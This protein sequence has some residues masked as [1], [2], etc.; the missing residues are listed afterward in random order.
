MPADT[1]ERDDDTASSVHSC[2]SDSAAVKRPSIQVIN[3][4]CQ[5]EQRFNEYSLLRSLLKQ[6]L[7]FHNND[8]TQPEREQYILRLF[9]IT[10]TDD[11]H[12]RQNLF[13]LNDLCDV[14]FQHDRIEAE[15]EQDSNFVKSYEANLNELLSHM[16]HKLI[17]PSAPSTDQSSQSKTTN[18]SDAP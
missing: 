10:H 13:L 17:E 16:L 9:D 18:S 12:L 7:Q 6:L 3:Y 11:L 15:S 1:P 8:K 4:R 2:P 5:F 14:H